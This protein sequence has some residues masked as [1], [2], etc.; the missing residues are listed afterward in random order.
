MSIRDQ[1]MQMAAG[2]PD[3]QKAVDNIEQQLS[4]T[5][6]MPDDLNEAIKLLEFVLQ[7][8][9]KYQEVLQAA[10]KDGIV[11]SGMMPEQFDQ[12][13]IISFLI[14]LYELQDR[15]S[16]KMAR[17]GI[18]HSARYL[19][20]Q[21]RGGDTELAHVNPREAEM[22][23]R[24]GGSG[25][26]NPNTGLR[27]YKFLGGVG[28]ILKVVAPIALMLVPGIGTAIGGALTGGLLG[29]AGSAIV[30]GAALGAGTSAWKSVV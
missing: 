17:G 1:I 8:P 5:P 6:I 23:R 11:D 21:G 22:L 15:S 16:Q 20:S 29:G 26:V 30:G 7:N 19:A 24:M 27:E 25:T 28:K 2:N 9:D 18:A 13:F 4:S 10:V 3:V 12:A 14:A